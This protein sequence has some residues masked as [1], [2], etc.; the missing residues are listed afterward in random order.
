MVIWSDSA[1]LDL[2]QIYDYVSR[3]SKIYGKKVVDDIVDRSEQLNHFSSLG[4]K[5][6][7]VNNPKIREILIYS[8][9]LIYQVA[10]EQDVEILAIVHTRRNFTL[11]GN[12]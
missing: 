3:D 10:S 6:T 5:V 9:R 4:K 7:E 8:Y 11:T 2:R 12:E 1:K